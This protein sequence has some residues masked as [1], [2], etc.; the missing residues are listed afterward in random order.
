MSHKFIAKELDTRQRMTLFV[1]R[2]LSV[3]RRYEFKS[4]PSNKAK[5]ASSEGGPTPRTTPK[6]G[7][8]EGTRPPPWKDPKL[9]AP[10]SLSSRLPQMQA[11]PSLQFCVGNP[12]T[13]Y[14]CCVCQIIS[15]SSPPPLLCFTECEWAFNSALQTLSIK[16]ITKE[17]AE[18]PNWSL[19]STFS[20]G[21]CPITAEAGGTITASQVCC[22]KASPRLATFSVRLG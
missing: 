15:V 2:G 4:N 21:H 22:L 17:I 7:G 16:A 13:A 12:L 6:I 5:R 20:Q 8:E 14:S 3:Q 19:K 10:G 9:L 11:A 1:C 18:K